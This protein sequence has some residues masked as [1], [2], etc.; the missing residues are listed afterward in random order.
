MGAG[1]HVLLNDPAVLSSRTGEVARIVAKAFSQPVADVS[2]RVRYGG[3]IVAREAPE[4]KAREI[5]ATLAEA[6][7]PSFV[8]PSA[9]I[10]PLPRARR[11]AGLV[12]EAD[13]LRGIVRGTKGAEKL[14]WNRIRAFHV[15]A[16]ARALSPAEIEEG[17]KPRPMA[18]VENAPDEV[19]RLTSEIDYWEDRERTK[20]I[21]LCLDVIADDA[22]LVGR[23]TADEADYSSLEGKKQG[24]LENFM[25]LVRALIARSPRSVIVPPT[26]RAFADKADWQSCLLDKPEQ[27]D[28][29]N[30]WLLSA[31]RYDKPFGIDTA[32]DVEDE[33]VDEVDEDDEDE[34][35]EAD[36]T[37]EADDAGTEEE[38]D[39]EEDESREENIKAA[40]AA[41]GDS[42]L[43]KELE[44]FDKTRKLRKQD[45]LD[46]LE[47]AKQIDPGILETDA[48]DPPPPSNDPD[49]QIFKE[50]TGRWDVSQLLE[51]TKDLEDKDL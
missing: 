22:V 31:V 5:A 16:L 38:E 19:R 21:D 24:A 12:I 6:R 28:A 37:D 44:L 10:E 42:A 35:D 45:V 51:E 17:R 26:T 33:E 46:A 13:G 4:D 1:F 8:I 39:D 9:A 36:D 29:Y 30:Q 43:A 27:R 7:I 11:M 2:Q 47:A 20:R 32:E 49:M 3:G 18:D 40:E 41:G 34:D 48:G 14:A 25:L 15:N 50:K 23:I